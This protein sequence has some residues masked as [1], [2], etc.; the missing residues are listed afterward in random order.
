ML[1]QERFDPN[2]KVAFGG[3]EYTCSRRQ[4]LRLDETQEWKPIR[5]EEIKTGDK[6]RLKD[7]DGTFVQHEDGRDTFIAKTNTKLDELGL[8]CFYI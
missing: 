6:I 1:Y 5:F 2:T 8:M 3:D 4:T 7:P